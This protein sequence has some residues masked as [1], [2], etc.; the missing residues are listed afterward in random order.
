MSTSSSCAAAGRLA[1]PLVVLLAHGSRQPRWAQP[2]E[3]VLQRL[4]E[5]RPDCDA[6][7]AFLEL[8]RPGLD[9]ALD[10][11][12]AAGRRR[13]VLV[14]LFL[15]AGGHLQRDIPQRVAAAMQRHPGLAVEVAA[16]AG[17]SVEVIAALAAC[18]AAAVGA[19]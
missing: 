15:G 18:A 4:R 3:A 17:E 5:A 8:M 6:A 10:A 14:P 19:A 2:F 9:E 11:A 16:A 13:V 12:A 7:L 1:R